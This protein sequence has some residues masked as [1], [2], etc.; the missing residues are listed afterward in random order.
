[1]PVAPVNELPTALAYPGGL[2][3]SERTLALGQEGALVRTAVGVCWWNCSPIEQTSPVRAKENQGGV[4]AH[5]I[6]RP[7]IPTWS[8]IWG[9]EAD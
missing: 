8:L 7:N 9:R 4:S 1:M 5:S 6:L 3:T 2:I